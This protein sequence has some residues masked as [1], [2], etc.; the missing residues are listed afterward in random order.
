MAQYKFYQRFKLI[1]QDLFK[2]GV[3]IST[4]SLFTIQSGLFLNLERMNGTS[5]GL[6]KL[7]PLNVMIPSTEI[8]ITNV[9]ETLSH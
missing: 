8:S 1:V 6:S 2:E 5:H 4:I 7:K 9:I 3:I